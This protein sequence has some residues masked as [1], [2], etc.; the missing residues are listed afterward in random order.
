MCL[1]SGIL[2]CATVSS[3]C[4]LAFAAHLV[5]RRIA[6]CRGESRRLAATAD[7]VA[8]TEA[9]ASGVLPALK[10]QTS[11][12]PLDRGNNTLYTL[13]MHYRCFAHSTVPSTPHAYTCPSMHSIIIHR[14]HIPENWVSLSWPD[15]PW[16]GREET[17][18]APSLPPLSSASSSSSSRRPRLFLPSLLDLDSVFLSREC[19]RERPRARKDSETRA[20]GGKE[21]RRETVEVR[22]LSR[23]EAAEIRS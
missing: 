4:T 20:E 9:P 8:S 1:K 7:A 19:L 5:T 18:P 14:K 17:P 10:H 3:A 6:G 16:P 22:H 23:G 15:A 21:G 13:L 11:S 2:T 12:T